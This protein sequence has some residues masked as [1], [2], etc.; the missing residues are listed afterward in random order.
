MPLPLALCA[1]L[2]SFLE[3]IGT[4]NKKPAI[5]VQGF[6]CQLKNRL[7]SLSI[8]CLL[9]LELAK[10]RGLPLATLDKD[11]RKAAQKAGVPIFLFH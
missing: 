9:A 1:P 10:R 11:L 5:F 3:T 7:R 8:G 6:S 2:L 4:S